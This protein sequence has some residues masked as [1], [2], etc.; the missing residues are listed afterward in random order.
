MPDPELILAPAIV[1][2][3]VETEPVLNAF[4]SLM[5]IVKA[6]AGVSGF[7][8]WVMQTT[9]ALS[10]ERLHIHKLVFNGLY[11]AVEPRQSWP[12]FEDYLAH[13]EAIEPEELRQRVLGTYVGP[14]FGE[15]PFSEQPK[16]EPMELLNSQEGFLSYLNS[17]CS[18]HGID[19]EIE[20][21]A[22]GYLQNPPAMKELIV[23]HLRTMWE[24]VMADEWQRVEPMIQES[25]DALRQ[26]N[27]S[28]LSALEAFQKVTG[29][30]P[31]EKIYHLLNENR[32]VVFV[33]SVHIGPYKHKIIGDDT[34]WI[35]FGARV[36]EGA[37]SSKPALSINDLMVQLGAL[38]D[39][40]R[41]RILALVVEYGELCTMDIME[42]LDLSQSTAQRHLKH[43]TAT[44]YLIAQRREGA[45]CF[46]LN[47]ARFD[48]TF[49]AMKRLLKA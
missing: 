23:S 22:F 44:G 39:E 31:T 47:S 16:P 9:Q 14:Y 24:D 38:A 8:N 45:K 6:N 18:T 4:N 48:Q 41:L 20:K 12:H 27:L 42:H 49:N 21:V 32:R 5:T 29:V 34:L 36:P 7:S 35:I 40:T 11:Y 17:C 1:E 28:G 10:K 15:V 13:M 2:A 25:V 33:P 26:I 43:L 46:S 37:E 19:E 3:T 30:E